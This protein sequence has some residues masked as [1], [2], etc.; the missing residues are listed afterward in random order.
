MWDVGGMGR[1]SRFMERTGSTGNV[2][3]TGLLERLRRS[4][5]FVE[6]AGLD[7]ASFLP[8]Q[9][10][11]KLI[12]F[13]R[14]AFLHEIPFFVPFCHSGDGHAEQTLCIERSSLLSLLPNRLIPR[15]LARQQRSNY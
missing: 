1:E 9:E 10:D 12:L 6:V 11:N 7:L 5:S 13:P 3:S 2:I 14:S 4:S 8:G 15:M